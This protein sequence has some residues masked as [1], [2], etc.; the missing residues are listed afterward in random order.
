MSIK[1]MNVIAFHVNDEE[2]KLIKEAALKEKGSLAAYVRRKVIPEKEFFE[3]DICIPSIGA[4]GISY[5]KVSKELANA[6]TNRG[7]LS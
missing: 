3:T 7:Y 1:R 6:A 2:Y 4:E 5:T